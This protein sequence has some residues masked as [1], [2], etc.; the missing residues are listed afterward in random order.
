LNLYY[1]ISK[2]INASKKGSFSAVVSVIAM[3]SIMMGIAVLL[4]SFAIMEG[5]NK[6]I[7]D[8]IFSFGSHLQVT[9]YDLHKS[10]EESPLTTN[11]ELFKHPEKIK[12]IA[13]IQAFSLKPCLL[14]T[15]EEVMG[16]VLKGVGQ[17]FNYASFKINMVAGSFIN[18]NNNKDQ[19]SKDILIS[20]KIADKLRLSLDDTVMVYFVQ[21]PPRY[22]K[23]MI[24]GIYETGLEEFDDLIIMGD[25]RLNQ[26]L[27]D[28]NDTLIGGYEIFIKDF[29]KLEPVSK[30]VFELMDYDMQLEK[31]TD[32]Y[33]QIFDWLT[34]L[35]RNVRIFLGL[36]VIVAFVNMVS[37]IFIMIMERTNMI[38]ILK[39]LGA[40]DNQIHTIFIFNGLFIILKGMLLGNIIGLGF[41]YLQYQFQFIPLDAENYY[42][43]T[44][45]IEWNWVTIVVLNAI[46]FF[47]ISIVLVLPVI[48]ISRIK[49]IQAIK[50]N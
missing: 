34:L 40:T 49:P 43:H 32:K 5:F 3:G 18:F 17:D 11:S 19:P 24:R 26:K 29:S 23:L 1:F 8:K 16:V 41:C 14:K 36:I 50:F 21:N 10:Y 46:T 15:E 7:Q 33:I 42:M 27:N 6:K 45:P 37:T 2:R 48:I 47:L 30:K 28:W 22:R 25:I 13:H 9:K 44:V 4:V 38:G 39:A 12:E 35:K 31:I 20:Q